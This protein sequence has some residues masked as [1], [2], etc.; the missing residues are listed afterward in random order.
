MK[1]KIRLACQ[2][3][4][5]PDGK[6]KNILLLSTDISLPAEEILEYQAVVHLNRMSTTN[7]V[8]CGVGRLARPEY[9]I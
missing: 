8:S 2:G 4:V 7:S 3:E 6:I 5:Q 9:A 1:C